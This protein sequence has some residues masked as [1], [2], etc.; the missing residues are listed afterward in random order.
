MIECGSQPVT[1]SGAGGSLSAMFAVCDAI[2][3][4]QAELP[5]PPCLCLC[6]QW[7]VLN[8]GQ[9]FSLNTIVVMPSCGISHV[10]LMGTNQILFCT[11]WLN[12]TQR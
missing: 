10:D 11:V 4:V 12:S 7:S 3:P 6:E 8:W 1:F 2:N 9:Y 5:L